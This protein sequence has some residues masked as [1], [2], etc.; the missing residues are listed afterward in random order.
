MGSPGIHPG[1]GSKNS[2][3]GSVNAGTAV[4][5]KRNMKDLKT[6]AL[7]MNRMKFSPEGDDGFDQIPDTIA[8]R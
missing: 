5:K 7:F 8:F 1:A 6:F 4:R 2:Q 3:Y